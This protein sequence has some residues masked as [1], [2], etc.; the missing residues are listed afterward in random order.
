M[1]IILLGAPGAGKGT[2]AK[3]LTQL[4]GSVQIS[5]GDILRGAVKAGTQGYPRGFMEGNVI[6]LGTFSKTLAGVGGFCIS[7]HEASRALAVNRSGRALRRSARV[8]HERGENGRANEHC[9]FAHMHSVV[10]ARLKI[11][12]GSAFCSLSGHIKQESP[13]FRPGFPTVHAITA[14]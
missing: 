8:R 14:C 11:S 13:D 6:Y 7:D 9:R 5:T 2:V 12:M 10:F 1:R 4:D 3:L